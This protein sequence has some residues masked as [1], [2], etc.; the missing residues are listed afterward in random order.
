ML[1]HRHRLNCYAMKLN[2]FRNNI[3]NDILMNQN[4]CEICRLYVVVDDLQTVPDVKIVLWCHK[5]GSIGSTNKLTEI[6][7]MSWKRACGPSTDIV[8]QVQIHLRTKTFASVC[9]SFNG[10]DFPFGY[11]F[12]YRKTQHF[13]TS[14]DE[15][16]GCCSSVSQSTR[17]MDHQ[18]KFFFSAVVANCSRRENGFVFK[19]TVS[20]ESTWII[21]DVPRLY[22]LCVCTSYTVRRF[23]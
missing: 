15:Q 6:S 14:S 12:G 22:V 19:W 23:T 9:L 21:H 17:Q 3:T 11:N 4:V 8:P 13:E 5:F 16:R 7:R 18:K 2:C 1:C 10:M 20:R